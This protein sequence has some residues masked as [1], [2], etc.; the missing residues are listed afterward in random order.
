MLV[1]QV[2][3]ALA[4]AALSG[5]VPAPVKHVLHEKRD[6]HVDWVKGERVKRDSV[7]P[8]RIGLTQNN[9]EKGEELLMTVSDPTSPK[10]GQYWSAEEVHDM[11]AP[12]KESVDSV[13]QWLESSGIDKSRVVHSDNKGWLAFDAYA[14][15]VEKLFMTEFYEHEHSH[16][17]SL[18]IGCEEYHVPEHIQH[19]IDY[20]TPGVKLSPIVKKSTKAKRASHLAHSK[21][22]IAS[23]ISKPKVVPPKAK[24]LPAELQ[25]CGSDMTPACIK[26]LYKIPDATKAKKG[27]SLGLYEQGDYFAKSDLD[28][29]YKDYA[30]WIPQGT[31]PI[32][33]L[34]DGANYSVPDYSALNSGE[35]DIDI[36]MAYALIY[37]Q[38]VTLYQVDDQVYEPVEVATTNLFNTFLDA[39]D[40]SYCTYSA[41]GETGNNPDID[42]VYPNPDPAGYKGKLQCG[43]YKPTNVISASYGQ[44][45][46]DLPAAYTKRQCN[47]FL[48][49]GLQGHSILFASGDYGVASFPGDGTPNGCLG[50]EGKIFNPQYPSNC[51]YVT[52]VGGT[53][54]YEDQTVHDAE[55]VMHA[56]LGGTAANFSSSGGFSNYFPQPLYQKAAVEKY[57]KKAKLSYPH[58]SGMNVNLNTTKGL[59]NRIG[60]AY[61]DV[62][63]NGAMFPAYTGGT[64][65]HYYGASLA[66]PLFASV[67]NLINEERLAKG[68]GPVGFVNPVLYAHPEVLNDI[69]NGTNVGCG[70][71]GF[72]AIPGWDPATGLGTPNYPKLKKLLLS[73]P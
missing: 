56:D 6:Q 65:H 33:A 9:L 69:T 2:C 48:K 49:L 35:S 5:A 71:E 14:H 64:V 50:P 4:I 34:I 19:H 68:K 17:A 11:F 28:L 42:P 66:S 12:P 59:F 25:N 23:D 31:Y 36:D 18:K 54:L 26:A 30:P 61:P 43:V 70:S 22:E 72:S 60:R 57:F 24:G 63:A 55:S 16:T 32:P 40:G 47:E 38:E 29:Y 27:N 10:Y 37:P 45:E 62:A 67:L 21:G 53:M 51:P 73:L 1:L 8:V 3:V 52:S 13:R 39:L 15:E 58:Y 7:L 41:Y 20:I 44:A 46:A